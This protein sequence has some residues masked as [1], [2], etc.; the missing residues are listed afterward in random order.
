MR[1][2]ALAVRRLLAA[3]RSN[4]EVQR[5]LRVSKSTVSVLGYLGAALAGKLREAAEEIVGVRGR[6]LARRAPYPDGL[7]GD[8]AE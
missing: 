3:T 8:L 1:P 5:R 6:S 7:A 2:R 4:T